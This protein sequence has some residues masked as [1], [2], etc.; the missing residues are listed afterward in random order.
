M[1]SHYR[2][3]K[4]GGLQ[5]LL[6]VSFIILCGSTI[7]NIVCM[8]LWP[9]RATKNLQNAM[10]QTLQ[11]FST[12]LEMLTDTFLL[13]DALRNLTNDK[14]AKAAES[15][16]ASFTSLKKHFGEAQSE[17]LLGGPKKPS[18]HRMT[19]PRESTGQ[20]YQDAIDSLNRLGQHLNGLRSGTT[21]QYELIKAEKNGK[22]VLRG[23][24]PDTPT[25]DGGTAASGSS[26]TMIEDEDA[27][28][29]QAAAA[30]F[31]DLIDDLGPPLKALS[32]CC[33]L[34]LHQN[35]CVDQ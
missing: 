33:P 32:V 19:D 14:L 3:V 4:E 27:A 22:L 17:W 9:Q 7:S 24:H 25:P 15:H 8:L 16:Q 10:M 18:G 20:A 34:P 21:L 35:F 1:T 23:H 2:V 11:S 30:M 26:A 28:M 6:Q 29:L 5:T 31:G 12:L 13:E